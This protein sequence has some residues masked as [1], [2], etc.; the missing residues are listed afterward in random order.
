MEKGNKM[1]TPKNSNLR[2]RY[3]LPSIADSMDNILVWA[4]KIT[5]ATIT[6]D[7]RSALISAVR[8]YK[9]ADGRRIN[10]TPS[11]R[12]IKQIIN[13]LRPENKPD[14]CL[15]YMIQNELKCCEKK[16]LTQISICLYSIS[17][18]AFTEQETFPFATVMNDIIND[19]CTSLS[20]DHWETACLRN[21]MN[22]LLMWVN[23]TT[24][25]TD[26]NAKS[27]RDIKT[28]Y[29]DASFLL[30]LII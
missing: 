8:Y 19:I 27:I 24:G 22:E 9:E 28:L 20:R 6:D 12:T 13:R 14:I 10:K 26:K 1:L 21:H 16:L 11:L 25:K 18:T 4:Q 30:E 29:Q 3:R 7:D 2:L 15:I 17:Y 5:H 23:R